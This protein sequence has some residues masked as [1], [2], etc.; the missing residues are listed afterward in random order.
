MT[1][2]PYATAAT[3]AAR[4]AQLTGK[5]RHDIAVVLGS[6][7]AAAADALG[8][9]DAQVA[10]AELGGF[11]EP[12]VPGHLAAVR[13]IGIAGRRVL[14]FLG[15]AHLYEGHSPATV[16]HGVRTAVAAGCGTL[17]L[18]NAAGGIQAGLRPGQPVLISDQLNLTGA[19]PLTGPPP[20]DGYPSRF[21]DLTGLYPANLRA[22]ARAAAPDLAEAVYAGLAGPHYETPA[23]IRMLR[24]CG[25]GLVGMSTVLEAI[26]AR[27]LDAQVLGIS[28][29]TNIAAGLS[30]EPLDHG[31][32]VAAGQR[33]AGALGVLLRSIL[34]GVS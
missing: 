4:L 8:S 10:M 20:P 13:S 6:G 1:A 14:V 3:S 19:S 27:H 23:E 31:E 34:A 15:R 33:E 22:T 12:T 17:V 16:V 24:S 2:D 5:P 9:P 28:L 7:W 30:P 26:A 29:V 25:A 11:P 21:T 32:V 18:T